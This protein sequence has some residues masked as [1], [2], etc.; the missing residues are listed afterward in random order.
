[1]SRLSQKKIFPTV[2]G[3]AEAVAN[4]EGRFRSLRGV[5]AVAESSEGGPCYTCGTG[6]VT[7]RV[8]IEGEAE[9]WDNHEVTKWETKREASRT[10]STGLYARNSLRN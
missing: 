2:S 3:Y 10:L 1:M 8:R 9:T 5:R 6:R 7:F 4:P